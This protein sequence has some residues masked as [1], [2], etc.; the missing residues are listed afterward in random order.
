MLVNDYSDNMKVSLNAILGSYECQ[1][2]HAE[3]Y[4]VHVV[5]FSVN[6]EILLFSSSGEHS[7]ELN[8]VR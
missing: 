2:Y 8:G 1:Q 7:R 5:K 4:F 6:Y 3:H